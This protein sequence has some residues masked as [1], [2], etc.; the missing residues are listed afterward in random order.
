MESNLSHALAHYK[1]GKYV[2]SQND[3]FS[4][5]KKDVLSARTEHQD[6]H[7]YSLSNMYHLCLTTIHLPA[8]CM[9]RSKSTH[10]G[11]MDLQDAQ[12]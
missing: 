9:S 2:W 7:M 4:R 3:S 5:E 12:R 8:T 10:E 1:S 11:D 6:F